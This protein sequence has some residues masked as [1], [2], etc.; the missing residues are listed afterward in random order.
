[1]SD[2]TIGLAEAPGKHL[3][4]TD[5]L[6]ARWAWKR[7]SKPARAAVEA[8]YPDGPV[9]GHPLTLNALERH[10]FMTGNVRL[11][12]AGKAVARWNVSKP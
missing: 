8:A 11:T 4:I 5:F 7:L 9:V 1:M 10:G 6:T 3:L 2:W 12:D